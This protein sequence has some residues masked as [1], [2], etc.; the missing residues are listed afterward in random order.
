[1]IFGGFTDNYY[2]GIR[3]FPYAV[4]TNVGTNGKPHNPLTLAD[5]DDAQDNLTDGAFPPSPLTFANPF[6]VHNIGEVWCMALLEVRAR[7]IARLGFATGNQ[8]IL[9]FVTDGMKLD[10][11]N[12]H[13]LQG[14]DSILTAANG[15]GGTQADIDDIWAGFAVRGMGLSAQVVNSTTGAVVEA[16]DV[17]ATSVQRR[18]GQLISD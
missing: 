16:F 13:L 8:R 10:P 2:Y 18:R 12:P 4:K 15:G 11:A 1:M 5:I 9:Q 3:R 14:R 7:F 6:E 17:P